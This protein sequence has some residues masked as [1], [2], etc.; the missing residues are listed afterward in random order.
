M[1]VRRWIL[2]GVL[3]LLGLVLLL[4]LWVGFRMAQAVD[5]MERLSA[6]MDPVS[7][8]VAVGD[9][10]VL[11]QRLPAIREAAAHARSA[12]GDPVV[13]VA[14]RLPW[15]GD[16]L[17]VVTAVARAAD[18]LAGEP[19]QGV[20]DLV[21]A[22]QADPQ[23]DGSRAAGST[24]QADPA[25]ADVSSGGLDLRPL[26]QTA[27]VLSRAVDTLLVLHAELASVDP[28]GLVGPV[29]SGLDR[30][31]PVVDLDPE[32][33][34]SAA[35]IADHLPELL[36]LDGARRYL[37]LALNPAELR[38]QGG[39][40]G[41]ALV[42]TL[43]HG[44]LRLTDQRG[45]TQLPEQA[46]PVLPLT[47]QEQVLYGDRLGRWIQDVVLTP[48]FPRSAEL[49]AA[50]WDRVVGERVD[51]V[52]ATD[53]V[54][55]TA[56]LSAVG[57]QIDVD[58][59]WVGADGLIDLLLR[60]AYLQY[61]DPQ[62]GDALYARAAAAAFA[63]LVPVLS[64]PAALMAVAEVLARQVDDG[65]LRLW[66]ADPA[67]QRVLAGSAVA[68]DFL[69]GIDRGGAVGLFLDDTT[70]GKL[71]VD[72]DARIDVK[73]TGCHGPQ[74]AARITL[75]L[76]Y[77]PPADIDR[78][79]AQVLG[80]GGAGL[81]AGWIATN[82]SLYT[83]RHGVLDALTRNGNPLGGA[84]AEIDGRA[85]HTVTSRLAPGGGESYVVEVPAPGGRLDLWTTP[86]VDAPGRVSAVCAGL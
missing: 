84:V 26:A 70:A 81:P 68:G 23:D 12:T 25:V 83:A 55:L 40:V 79:P 24:G 50:Y 63:T 9:T 41:S 30:L 22:V 45:T 71:G 37:L 46:D 1:T 10:S 65:R 16:D 31:A 67:E 3:L 52:V 35:G 61:G 39:I 36:A 33:L 82:L 57:G 54:A 62:A 29:R 13:R 59:Q 53:P 80:D 44:V 66:S 60:Q 51:G 19:A 73:L 27:P 14:A 5:A 17:R 6:E 34:R 58:G 15:I 86:T 20:L 43:D 49:A 21:T 47:G 7:T 2:R 74:P 38:T 42:L 28:S 48:D 77:H 85:V 78:A 32:A 4:G 72:L 75:R 56:V 18:R 64:R 76:D 11:E 69:S 8:A